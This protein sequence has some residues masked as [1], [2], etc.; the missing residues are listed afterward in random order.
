M[1]DSYV[2]REREKYFWH[3]QKFNLKT[4]TLGEK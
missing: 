4:K 1:N 2:P 3:M